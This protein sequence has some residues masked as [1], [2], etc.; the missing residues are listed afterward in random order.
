[1]TRAL[2]SLTL[3]LLLTCAMAT[4]DKKS[5]EENR[6]KYM[7]LTA[8][9]AEKS[10]LD[11]KRSMYPSTE[12]YKCFKSAEDDQL[13]KLYVKRNAELKKFYGIMKAC[14]KYSSG[15]IRRFENVTELMV[16]RSVFISANVNCEKSTIGDRIA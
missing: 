6:A 16:C 15:T 7:K 1:M 11:N 13:W 5:S 3:G 9:E 4:G 12:F 10:V 8:Y 14:S 2:F